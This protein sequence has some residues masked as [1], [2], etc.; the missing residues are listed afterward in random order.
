MTGFGAGSAEIS[1]GRVVLELR[2]LN[3]KHQDLRLRMPPEIAEHAFFLEQKARAELGRGR[4]DMNVRL[5]GS[6]S[7]TPRVDEERLRSLYAA[8]SKIR[9][10][11][12]PGTHIDLAPLLALPEVVTCTAPDSEGVKAALASAFEQAKRALLVMHA[13][14]GASLKKDLTERLEKVRTLTEDLERSSAD[15]VMLG[16]QR[17][18]ERVAQLLEATNTRVNEDR[19]EQEIALLADKSD[20][21]EELVRLRSHFDQFALLLEGHEPVGRRLDFLLQEISR[22][23]NTVGSKSQHCKTAYL[24][25]EM[26]SEVERLREQVQNVD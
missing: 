6:A 10:E 22:E 9:D 8:I 25:V 23:V 5:E 13:G 15:L 2:S 16:R 11:L 4:Y 17:L 12:A 20:I 3:H 14:E 7:G 19:L 26:K 24:V 1:A 18:K 21:T